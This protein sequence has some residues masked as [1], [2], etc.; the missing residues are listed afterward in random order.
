MKWNI[1]KYFLPLSREIVVLPDK[2]SHLRDFHAVN[3]LLHVIRITLW[4]QDPQYRPAL[5]SC[6]FVVF[7]S[8]LF[9][10]AGVFLPCSFLFKLRMLNK[11]KFLRRFP[12]AKC[13][14]CY[15]DK[16]IRTGQAL[17]QSWS[18]LVQERM[19]QY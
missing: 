14:L 1:W 18:S 16:A 8:K 5:L 17:H 11:R 3:K 10:D 6:V 19:Y 15:A 12:T 7:V 2:Q 9:Y 4:T 13:Y